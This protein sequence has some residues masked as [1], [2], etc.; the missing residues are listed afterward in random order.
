MYNNSCEYIIKQKSEGS[1]L[2]KKLAAVFAC[3]AIGAVCSS[4]SL[5]LPQREL[6]FTLLLASISVSALLAFVA[7]RLLSIEYEIT[8]EAGELT[9]TTIY[10]RIYR[11][12]SLSLTLN[13]ISE[14]G[15]Y[16]DKIYD[17][18]CKLSLQKDYICL[19]SLSAPRVFYAIFD[20]EKDNCILYFDVTEKAEEILRKHIPSAFR[21]SARRINTAQSNR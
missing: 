2:Y 1:A 8:V 15:E 6:R 5:S 3:V 10:G 14:I 13:S 18:I 9:V 19:S 17:E 11:K 4:L 7:F 21:A 16:N 12:L 20:D